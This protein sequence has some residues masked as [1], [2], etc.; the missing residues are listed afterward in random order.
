[1]SLLDVHPLKKDAKWK[2]L[3]LKEGF[4]TKD[5]QFYEHIFPYT[6]KIPANVMQPCPVQFPTEQ[7][8]LVVN[9]EPI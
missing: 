8:E 7:S 5:V 2:N 1:M 6:Y 4:V 9:Q 3:E